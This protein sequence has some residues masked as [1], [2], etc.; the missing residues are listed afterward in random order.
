MAHFDI[1]SP[2]L[3]LSSPRCE[4]SRHYNN[5]RRIE[6]RLLKGVTHALV[7][8][9]LWSHANGR[10]LERLVPRYKQG[11]DFSMYV[12]SSAPNIILHHPLRHYIER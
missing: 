1:P 3:I 9:D 6:P 5:S 7:V 4:P 8:V 12:L 10:E 2:I 11:D